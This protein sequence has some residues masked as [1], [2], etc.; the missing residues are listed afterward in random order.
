MLY[1]RERDLRPGGPSLNDDAE[2]IASLLRADPDIVHHRRHS[3]YQPLAYAAYFGK[4][5]VMEALIAA[6]ADTTSATKGHCARRT[7]RNSA[8]R[9]WSC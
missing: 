2:G 3:Q 8:A 9:R 1:D 5:K 6:D 4:I 7:I